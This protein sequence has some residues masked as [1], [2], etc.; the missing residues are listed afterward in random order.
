[1]KQATAALLFAL[2]AGPVAAQ[3]ASS[4]A[5]LKAGQMDYTTNVS[6]MGQELVIPSTRTISQ[7]TQDG[8]TFWRIVDAAELPAVA[9]GGIAVD[10]FEVM[11]GTLM[12]LRRSSGS[13][14]GTLHFDYD[15]AHVKG[16]MQS[17]MGGVEV[18][19]TFG[20]PLVGDG[21]AFEVF[22]SGLALG[23]DFDQ[24]FTTYSPQAQGARPIRVH[25]TGEQSVTTP[26]GTFDTF[27]V[28]YAPQDDNPAGKAT[29]YVTKAAPHVTVRAESDLGPQMNGAVAVIELQKVQ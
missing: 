8:A 15:G 7:V 28:D 9:G 13:M 22:L 17:M 16:S 18:D 14:G 12:P 5:A 10:T 11:A 6:V 3:V 1:M 25:V 4:D 19:S 27:V 23:P 24:T 20:E 21:A 26:A 29:L 2:V